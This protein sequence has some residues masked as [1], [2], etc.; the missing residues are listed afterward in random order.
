MLWRRRYQT[1]MPVARECQGGLPRASKLCSGSHPKLKC[2]SYSENEI[3]ETPAPT[4]ALPHGAR[5]S[6]SA[7]VAMPP[8]RAELE[9]CAP[10][11]DASAVLGKF[12]ALWRR[13]AAR[14]LTSAAICLEHSLV[15]FLAPTILR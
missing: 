14:G 10:M 6:S 2:A 9:L 8:W 15:N 13:T 11:G 7:L 3:R 5:S 1:E 4:S 12:H